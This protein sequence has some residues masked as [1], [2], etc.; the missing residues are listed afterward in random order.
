VFQKMIESDS[1]LWGGVV[2]R[3]KIQVGLISLRVAAEAG[4]SA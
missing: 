3:A 1:T 4:L 2:K